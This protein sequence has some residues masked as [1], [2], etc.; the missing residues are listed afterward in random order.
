MAIGIQ[1]FLPTR[2]R[3]LPIVDLPMMVTIFF[4]V[5]RRNPITG[6][7]TG[8]ILGILQDTLAGPAHPIGMYGI[9]DTVIGFASSSLGLKID[10]D[11]AGSRFLITYVFFI[12][13]QAIYFGVAHG[14]LRQTVAW[15][16]SHVALSALVNAFSACSCMG[17]W[18]GSSR[19]RGQVSAITYQ[20]LGL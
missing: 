18:I 12:A 6:C 16:W 1:A 10:V 4:A 17:S 11:N 8:A 7:L 20:L 13:H 5:A 14:L 9:A 19:D 15:S 2:V 3:F